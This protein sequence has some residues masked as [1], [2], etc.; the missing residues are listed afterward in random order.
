MSIAKIIMFIMLN[1]LGYHPKNL[2]IVGLETNF[3]QLQYSFSCIERVL[4]SIFMLQFLIRL[5]YHV[6]QI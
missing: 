1:E 4:V 3:K 6:N 2:S 5:C